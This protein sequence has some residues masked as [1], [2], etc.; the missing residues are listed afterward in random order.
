MP[1]KNDLDI[2]SILY[3]KPEIIWMLALIGAICTIGV[4]DYLRCF[5]EKK[6]NIIR[7]VV[8]ITSLIVAFVLSPIVHS[9]ITFIVILW[10]LI[11]ALATIGK[12]HII[13]G[14]GNIVN[15]ITDTTSNKKGE[16]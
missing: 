9:L 7:Y 13:D 4:V 8:L 11:L 3:T 16:K 14:I 12:K 10:L 5:F 2:V 1:E 15:K 6:K